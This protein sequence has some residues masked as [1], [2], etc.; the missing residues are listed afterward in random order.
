MPRLATSI[1]SVRWIATTRPP[2]APTAFIV[3]KSSFL[4]STKRRTALATPTPPTSSAVRPTRVR[5]WVKRSRLR[6]KP[7]AA[8]ARERISQPA[9]RCSR[10]GGGEQRLERGVVGGGRR[11]RDAVGPAHQAAGLEQAGGAQRLLRDQEARP[12]ADAGGDLVRLGDEI[13]AQLQP[14][15]A[16]H[17]R[18]AGLQ[19]EPAE[20]HG[21][22]DGAEAVVAAGEQLRDR[23]LRLGRRPRR[24]SDSRHRP[25]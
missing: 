12:E 16:D 25:P 13:G 14:G 22:G 10:R 1:T 9:S 5:N 15:A 21:V 20:Q 8:L 7:G 11:Q 19:V 4:A 6:W 23:G 2:V 18:V 24:C 3:A 17:D